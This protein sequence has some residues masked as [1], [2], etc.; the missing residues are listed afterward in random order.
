MRAASQETV[1]EGTKTSPVRVVAYEDLQCGD[2]AAYRVMLD[3]KLLPKY[4]S[5]VAFEHR[6]FPLPKHSWARPAAVSARYFGAIHPDLGIVFRRFCL[7]VRNEVAP[8]AFPEAVRDFATRNGADPAKAVAALDDVALQNQVEQEYREGVA[9]GVSR[10][11]TVFVNGEP[12]IET[13][14]YEEISKGID[15]ALAAAGK[16]K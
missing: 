9:R 1:V 6:E 3:E 15:A 10:T 2:C 11:P 5:S 8:E 16:D 7:E 4:A 12:F 13:F 14:T